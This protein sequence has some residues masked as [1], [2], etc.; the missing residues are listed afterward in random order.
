[1]YRVQN[2]SIKLPS[3]INQNTKKISTEVEALLNKYNIDSKGF[4][5]DK[6]AY[7]A[8]QQ[9]INS[10][11]KEAV[12]FAVLANELISGNKANMPSVTGSY[13]N[14]FLGKICIQ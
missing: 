7:M 2:A 3:K 11:N 13:K 6:S 14:V 8:I 4:T 5:D 10:D 12:L 9:K 1:M